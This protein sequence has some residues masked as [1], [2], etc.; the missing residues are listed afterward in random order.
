MPGNSQDEENVS[1]FLPGFST[2]SIWSSDSSVSTT[3]NPLSKDIRADVC[4]VGA[5]IAGLTVAYFLAAEGKSVVV[6]DK[7]PV[8]SGE[9]INTSAHL[10]SAID[11]GYREIER[12]HG[13]RGAKLAA[14]SHATAI[15]SIES[16]ARNERVDCD[17][18]RIDGYLF[19]GPDDSFEV[20]DDEFAAAR[21]AGVDVEK[22]EEVPSRMAKGPCLKFPNQA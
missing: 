13:E 17:F 8:G 22:H 7:K 6:I 19:L 5:G 1:A 20:L 12:Y 16:I 9:T 3:L 10:S 21:R 15:A 2:C 4:V 14:E 18:K 11:A